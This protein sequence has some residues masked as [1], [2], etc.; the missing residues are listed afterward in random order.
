[1]DAKPKLLDLVRHKLRAKHYSYRTEQQY[2]YWIRRFVLYHG[3]RHPAEMSAPEVEAF[4]TDLAINR[5]VSASTQNQ[6]LASLL[7]LYRHVLEIDLPWLKSVVRAR[8]AVHVPVVL[9]RREVQALLAQLDGRF[10][11]IG[12][13]LYGSGLRVMEVLR[14]RVKDIDLEYSQIVVRD[15]KGQKDR[16]TI[17]PEGVVP[18]LRL[19]LRVVREQHR[20]AIGRGFGVVSLPYALEH[21]YPNAP[22]D[23]A[24]QYVFPADR[25]SRDPRTGAVV[26]HHMHETSVQRVIR[27]AARN[28][29][30]LKPVGPHTLRHC[31]A[32]H[33][34]ER[35]YD[36]RTVQELMG[37]ADVRTTQIYT[38]VMKKGAGAVKSPLD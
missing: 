37:H 24:W 5:R 1:M 13:L 27:R 14:L 3:K 6:A 12:Q 4:L 20:S 18:S 22:K 26:L 33:L 29:G 8:P 28:T 30:I 21:K 25:P 10:R 36:I 35:G 16:V 11:L 15:G 19:H 32:T 17:L 31:F 23:W 34:L 2:I 9:S 7:F 38:H